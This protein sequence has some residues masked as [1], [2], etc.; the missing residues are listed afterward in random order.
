MPPTKANAGSYRR[1]TGATRS[2]TIPAEVTVPPLPDGRAWTPEAEE[3]WTTVHSS[4]MAAE[5]T[6][7]DHLVAARAMRLVDDEAALEADPDLTAER[8]TR[9][10]IQISAELRLLEASLGLSP[11]A[12]SRLRVEIVRGEDA[13]R[14]RGRSG[15]AARPLPRMRM[16]WH[17]DGPSYVGASRRKV[18]L[19]QMSWSR[20]G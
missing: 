17:G 9:L 3:W 4:A 12:R 6:A 20:P 18:S 16:S 7:D 2:I 15:P 13:E 5:W 19:R 8:R 11:A 14:R 1:R 10:R